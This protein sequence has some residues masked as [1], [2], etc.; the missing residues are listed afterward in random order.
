VYA[1][2][3]LAVPLAYLPALHGAF[4]WNDSDYVT[5]PALRSLA[6]LWRI[7]FELG[8]TQQY[9]PVLHTAFWIEHG[10]W[11]DSALG[12]HLANIVLHAA[13]ACLFVVILRRL[14]VPG[15][16]FAGL[17]FALHPVC[18]ESVA[19]ISEQKNTLSTAFYLLAALAYLNWREVEKE[20][21]EI[22]GTGGPPVPGIIETLTK[23]TD[24]RAA[25]PCPYLLALALFI[26]AVLSKSVAATLPAALL[27]VLWWKKGRLDW[28][29]D[30]VPL[31]PWIVI[32]AAAGL[33]TAWVERTF[34][35]AQ[36]SDFDLGFVG[37]SLVAGR[38]VWFYLGKLVWP[39]DLI[40]I[41]PRWDVD[42]SQAWQYAFPLAA[43]ALLCVLW[44]WR[45]RSRAPLAA[46]GVFLASLIPVLGFFNVYAFVFS[47]VADHFQ[48]LATLGVVAGL[49]AGLTL[50][51]RRLPVRARWA[52]PWLALGL[53]GGLGALT[54]RQCGMY[55]DGEALYREILSRNPNSWMAQDNLGTIL[56]QSGRMAE[57]V[58]HYEQALG[59]R[60]G[61]AE[62]HNNL[63]VALVDT[64]H[65]EEAIGQFE[66]AVRLRSD[67]PEAEDNLA[68]ALARSGQ[69]SR[70]LGIFEELLRR[71][72]G[73]AQAHNNY[74]LALAQAGRLPEAADQC[75]EA[76]RLDPGY[77]DARRNLDAIL[78]AMEKGSG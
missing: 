68:S 57:A 25:R 14:G 65:T 39:A 42:A 54:Y 4:I 17:V 34:I 78:A 30:F 12:Y 45:S 46:A 38:A 77:A 64:G 21:R 52:G 51:W 26:L 22:A 74:G 50:G 10:L 1:L 44:G 60:P 56:R 55:R 76:L 7:W 75:R 33:F 18:A 27:V 19:W 5:K 47:F 8:A 49:A 24:G 13:S 31:L 53:A 69:V 37:R 40:F 72:P 61:F 67:F 43:L 3:V 36:G 70:A 28:R 58:F 41:Y 9:Y 48:Y 35:G 59:A 32:G 66:R 71:W 6:G 16:A 29:R 73:F 23:R 63:G 11:G 62:G 2:I 20:E 15:A